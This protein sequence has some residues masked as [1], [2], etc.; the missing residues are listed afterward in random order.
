MNLKNP[1]L[2]LIC[3]AHPKC[4]FYGFMIRFWN[5]PQKRTILF[6]WILKSGFGFFQKNA[7]FMLTVV[8]ILIPVSTVSARNAWDHEPPQDILATKYEENKN[9]LPFW[10]LAPAKPE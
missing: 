2:D 5:C 7:P 8:A 1:D 9:G 10:T 4:E 3:R 6:F